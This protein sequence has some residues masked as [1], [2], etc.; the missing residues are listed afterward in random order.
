ML[1]GLP[2]SWFVGTK[3]PNC[4]SQY[5]HKSAHPMLDRC[6]GCGRARN[7]MRELMEKLEKALK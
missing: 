2:E 4:G 6:A 1:R 3:C 7:T 5:V